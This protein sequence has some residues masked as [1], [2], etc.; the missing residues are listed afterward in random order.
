MDSYKVCK[1]N[2]LFYMHKCPE[3]KSVQSKLKLVHRWKISEEKTFVFHAAG[4]QT[5]YDVT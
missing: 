2:I 4:A 3:A 1:G 5:V